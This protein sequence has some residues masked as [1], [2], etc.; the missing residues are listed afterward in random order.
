MFVS[1][2]AMIIA[3]NTWV[4]DVEALKKPEDRR[5]LADNSFVV[6]IGYE[7]LFKSNSTQ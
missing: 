4:S 5:W 7:K 2:V 6:S 3:S 1:G